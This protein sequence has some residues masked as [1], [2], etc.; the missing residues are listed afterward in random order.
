MKWWP[1]CLLSNVVIKVLFA[2]SPDLWMLPFATSLVWDRLALIDYAAHSSDDGLN[3]KRRQS[4][5]KWPASS[6]IW[7]IL[8]QAIWIHCNRK[9][10]RQESI[11]SEVSLLYHFQLQDTLAT[12]QSD[13]ATFAWDGRCQVPFWVNSQISRTLPLSSTDK[14]DSPVGSL[15][16]LEL[17][18][19]FE[20]KDIVVLLILDLFN[21]V[22]NL[23]V[24]GVLASECPT[25]SITFSSSPLITG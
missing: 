16:I 2:F 8:F 19:S 24:F 13:S 9:E 18:L 25:I 4:V 22:Q 12:D 23:W 17:D 15:P 10:A 20:A 14:T 1:F 7:S 3:L 21:K 6:T 11:W 5:K